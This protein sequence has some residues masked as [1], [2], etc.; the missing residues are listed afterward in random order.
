MKTGLENLI[1][2]E[3]NELEGSWDMM[4]NRTKGKNSKVAKRNTS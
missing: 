1:N 2:L 3:K 4:G